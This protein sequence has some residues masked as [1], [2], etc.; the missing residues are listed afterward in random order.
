MYNLNICQKIIALGVVKLFS[1]TM[2]IMKVFYI[3]SLYWE[4]S[5]PSILKE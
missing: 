2:I 5:V 1:M 3:P 4:F